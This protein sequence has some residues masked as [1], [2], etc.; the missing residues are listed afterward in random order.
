M[1][2][3]QGEPD[4]GE[5]PHVDW[6]THIDSALVRDLSKAVIE[7]ASP[8]GHEGDMAR[9]VGQAMADIG[10][11]VSYQVLYDDRLNVVGRW[12][13]VNRGPTVLYSGHLDTSVV[14]DEPWLTGIG[15][16]NTAVFENGWVYG[17]GIFNMKCA[18]VSYLAMVDAMKRAG[19]MPPGELIVAGTVGEIELSPV[20]EFQGKEF[21]SYGVGTRFLLNHGVAADFHVLGEPSALTPLTG[22]MGTVWVKL[23]THG[24]FIHTA[25]TGSHQD[26]I[27]ASDRLWEALRPWR[28][29]FASTHAMGSVPG[30]VNR[31]AVRGGLPWRAAR[32]AAQCSTY[33]DL[34]FH[35]KS[36]PIDIQREV[37]EA[38]MSASA[39][40]GLAD[41]GVEF[42]MSRPGTALPA[43]HPLIAMMARSHRQITGESA[44]VQFSPPV[45][46]DAIDSNRLG[47]PTVVYGP[48]G[49]AVSGEVDLSQDPRAAEGEGVRLE[50]ME[51]AAAVYAQSALGL[52][53][54]PVD[55]VQRDRLPMPAVYLEE[56]R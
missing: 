46:T 8:T 37:R 27:E 13:G 48:A 12:R 47:I 1:N 56:E 32:T 15:W 45:C 54:T 51:I 5:S 41:V 40:A 21:D 17:N 52:L 25:F 50:D 19:T 14:G 53:H 2:H 55:Q 29:N 3:S 18:F 35:P 24:D 42:Y 44:A 6:S 31:A 20:D 11:E 16:K 28:E 7:T 26:A 49:R 10:M 23:T 4:A 38:V 34:R 22:M 30:R 33:L 9:L 43:S 39:A 36:A